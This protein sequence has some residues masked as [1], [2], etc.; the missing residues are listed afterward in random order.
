[1]IQCAY[2]D[3]DSALTYELLVSQM[4]RIL[5]GVTSD[6]SLGFLRGH[7]AKLKSMGFEVAFLSSNGALSGKFSET[8][9]I[10]CLTVPMAREPAPLADFIS[11]CKIVAV[12]L[13]FR[14]TLTNFGTPK[15]GLLGNIAALLT[16]VPC[17]IYTLHGLRLETATGMKLRIL[18]WTEWTAC[19]C[20]HRVI[21]VS[22]SLR[23]RAIGLGLVGPEKAFVLGC[24]TCNGVELERFLPTPAMMARC[25]QLRSKL[26]LSIN[27]PVIGFV[28]R[29]TRDKGI[30]E[31][32]NAFDQLRR[33]YPALQLLLVGDFEDGDP[34]SQS[35]RTRIESDPCIIRPGFVPDTSPY[36]HLMDV[37][38][39]PTY[40]EGF[41]VVSLEAQAAGKPVV[42]TQA[43]GAIDSVQHGKTGLVVPV[44]DAVALA[45]AI[46][47]LLADP[48]K[49]EKLGHT[50]QQWVASVFA[51]DQVRTA[52]FNEYQRLIL[53]K[54]GGRP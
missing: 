13:R 52:L 32:L 7:S 14:P 30:F 51:G 34:V 3:A 8:E 48:A 24:G 11:L 22:Q 49:R 46:G 20:A 35:V 54:L 18:R 1:V 53:E 19:K 23:Q 45:R 29:F 50:G 41:A 12:L 21:C 9:G 25:A 2:F 47:V 38:V 40:R 4:N 16:R 5:Y 31:L 17:R 44:G 26:N 39:L 37:L 15:A 10:E 43:T 28:G 27:V 42:T 36:Y 33:E 6:L